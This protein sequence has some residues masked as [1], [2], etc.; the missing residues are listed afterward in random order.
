MEC[1][2][3]S[4]KWEELSI[5]LGLPADEIDTIKRNNPDNAQRCWSQALLAWIRQC[6]DT[7][8]YGKPSWRTLLRAIAK[9]NKR[10]FE[11]LSQDH[12]SKQTWAQIIVNLVIK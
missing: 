1:K 10:L 7:N 4:A 8:K 12:L 11:T 9:E 2:T 3:L 6:Y 5:C